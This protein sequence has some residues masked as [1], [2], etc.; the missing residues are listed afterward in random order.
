MANIRPEAAL[1]DKLPV[2]DITRGIIS[3]VNDSIDAWKALFP[4]VDWLVLSH[5]TELPFH[6][7]YA[8]PHTLG[9]DRIALVAAVVYS[10]PAKNTLVIDA[11][12]CVT[13]DFVDKTK[14]YLGGSISP[15]LNMRLTAM[16]TF[17]ARLPN[18]EVKQNVKFIGDSTATSMQSGALYGL[19][20]EIEGFIKRYR[21]QFAD[22]HI[23]LTGG[24]AKTL[25]P[26]IKS[27]IFA[28]P[29]FLLEGLHGILAYNTP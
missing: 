14:S 21:E 10:F 22:L 3:T 9:L 7:K 20:S 4:N 18:V 2:S 23:V 1:L 17:T 6:N 5:K 13:Y 16:A 11:G 25:A 12:T 28:R 27:N 29:N 8:T 15:G 24:D 26:L 19:V